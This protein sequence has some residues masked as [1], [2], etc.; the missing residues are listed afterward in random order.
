[1]EKQKLFKKD[2]TILVLGQ[3]ISLFGNVILRFALSM[4]VLDKTGSVATFGTILA[5]S[6]IPTVLLSSFG[7]I[8]ADRVNKRNIMV[9]LDFLTSI[10]IVSFIIVLNSSAIMVFISLLMVLLAIIQAF[11]QP[12]VQSSIPVLV[13]ENHLMTANGIVIQISALANLLGPILGGLLYGFFGIFPILILSSICFFISAVMEIFLKIPFNKPK[14]TGNMISIVTGDF[15]E[16]LQFLVKEQ[17]PLLKLL[18][19]VAAINVFLSAMLIIGLPFL[20]KILL[21]LSNQLY[22]FA[23]AAMGIG[24]IIGG[25]SA[26]LLAK[27]LGFK[28]SYLLLIGASIAVLPIGASV[29]GLSHSIISYVVILI[30]VALTM[31]FA[32]L[33]TVYA[34]T[35]MQKLTPNHLLGKVASV[36]TVLSMCA[37]PIGQAL[38]GVLF[39][40]ADVKSY[41]V[42]FLSAIICIGIGL[43]SKKVIHQIK[44]EN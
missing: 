42:I 15:K 32:T 12:S 6:M 30:S 28:K 1:M 19:L 20:I 37:L 11:Y 36:V 16:T 8:I 22:G 38:Y 7:G 10:L 5:L 23:E 2:F 39:K 40:V 44:V 34:Q 31:F 43:L 13:H 25:I 3:I 35:M 9:V 24:S 14:S 41:I 33:F 27:K 26:G 4:Y 21:G 18:A 17:K 29:I